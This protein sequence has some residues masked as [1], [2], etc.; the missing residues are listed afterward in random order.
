MAPSS[1]AVGETGRKELS[2]YEEVPW[3]GGRALAWLVLS[4]PLCCLGGEKHLLLFVLILKEA[5]Q[6]RPTA[7]SQPLRRLRWGLT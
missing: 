2:H 7:R 6:F 4:E 5:G 3:G 1:V